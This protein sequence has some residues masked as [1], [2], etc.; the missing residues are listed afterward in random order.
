MGEF[1]EV[2]EILCDK[3]IQE[4]TKECQAKPSI[5]VKAETKAKT[6]VK[7][8]TQIEAKL[9]P[10]TTLKPLSISSESTAATKVTEP[11]VVAIA[12]PLTAPI[13]KPLAM[14][15]TAPVA[16]PITR[17]LEINLNKMTSANKN[18]QPRV[19]IPSATKKRI[20]YKAHYCCEYTSPHNG[21]RCEGKYQ[22]QIDHIIPLAK[23]GGNHPENLRILCRTHNL[24]E[25]RRWGLIPWRK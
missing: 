5:K 13:T 23:G 2:I 6:K 19:F 24:A 25:A 4:K 8:K 21:K 16:I 7:V 10:M 14:P 1:A 17:P 3:L 12:L 9:N 15:M 18:F 11:N 22:L 20:F